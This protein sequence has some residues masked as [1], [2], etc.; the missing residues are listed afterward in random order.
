MTALR[1]W[2]GF[3][4]HA[5]LACWMAASVLGVPDTQDC[6]GVLGPPQSAAGQA[7]ACRQMTACGHNAGST[8]C[9]LASL[10]CAWPAGR[11]HHRWPVL[12][13]FRTWLPQSLGLGS[14]AQPSIPGCMQLIRKQAPEG[15]AEE[16]D[17]PHSLLASS[18][19]SGLM[20]TK[21]DHSAFKTTTIRCV[22]WIQ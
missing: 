17:G 21:G 7:P 14:K 6:G 18:A 1:C 11:R 12:A 10:C 13:G 3:L 8:E 4:R 15:A 20:G 19:V 9:A 22:V 2:L 5:A 16:A